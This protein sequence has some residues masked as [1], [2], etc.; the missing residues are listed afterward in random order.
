[1][2]WS[3]SLGEINT[4]AGKGKDPE[5][6]CP[7][8]VHVVQKVN[9]TH[10]YACGSYAYNPQQAFI[11]IERLSMVHQDAARGR[12]P[13]SPFKRSSAVII[14]QE[15]FAATTTDFWGHTPQIFRFLSK[16]GRPDVTLDSSISLLED[17][18]FVSA[19]L[20]PAGQKLY[21]FFTEVGKEF[22]FVDKLQIPRVAQVCKDDVG[23][24]RILQKKWTSFAKS[25]LLC[26]PP[27]QP[28]F[29]NLEDMFTLQPPEGADPSETLFYGVF[30]SQWSRRP[31]S[32]VCVFRLQDIQHAFAGNF[33]TL[34]KESYQPNSHQGR[35]YLGKCGL[36]NSSDSDLSEVKKN[37]LTSR[38]IK[39]VRLAVFSSEH[40][41]SRVVVMKKQA[42]NGRQYDVMFLLTESGFLQKL[43]SLD[44]GP[45][46]IEEI[47]VFKEPQLVKS[48]I[49]SPSKGVLY[50]GTSEGV[51]AVPA[52][53]CE[54][55]RSCSQCVLARDPLCGWS[56]SS[57]TCIGL[58]GGDGDIVQNLEGSTMG[59]ECQH[60]DSIP[61]VKEV[62]VQLDE[63][64]NL[65][66]RKPSNLAKLS[67]SSSE[68]A[69]LPENRF[70]QAADGSLSFLASTRS[71]GSY[72]CEAEEDGV[73]E[74]VVT[75]SVQQVA[76]PRHSL[77]TS[78]E[79][80]TVFEDIVTEKPAGPQDETLTTRGEV[81][82]PRTNPTTEP[83]E[84][85]TT[86]KAFSGKTDSVH[87]GAVSSREDR[88]SMVK[89]G[90][91]VLSQ[92]SYHSE[93]V[94]VSLLLA[95]C[96]LILAVGSFRIW[97]QK[98]AGPRS[99][100]PPSPED[101]SKTNA[102]TEICSLSSLKEAGPDQTIIL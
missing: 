71:F 80:R 15:L 86:S 19:S 1:M 101:G 67:W 79:D 11:D 3:P 23:G 43:V 89:P 47:Q 68:A 65:P 60:V 61:E 27:E 55:Y 29:N 62:S 14:D 69:V 77:G 18:T 24:Q 42:A 48:M 36:S 78:T 39:A 31:E 81:S 20:D 82:Q 76:A 64:V 7:N 59:E 84:P 63:V 96:I 41:Y 75:Y 56:R 9:S 38:Q 66:C 33:L 44:Q 8:F 85:L 40:K 100:R 88:R 83:E 73:R 57:R 17:P 16:D 95:A 13:F 6:E 37:F 92:R 22:S 53:R 46:V 32:A 58:G 91:D 10:L 45:R 49:L 28:P 98:K 21:F 34:E 99:M 54:S 50:V 72:R 74:V 51:T 52:A 87:G 12:C 4:C 102:S 35:G 90:E 26:Q 93:L 70:I 97:R 30:T 2:E 5:L 94:V 25:A